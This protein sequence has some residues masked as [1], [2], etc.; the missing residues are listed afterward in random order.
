MRYAQLR[1]MI[2]GDIVRDPLALSSS[3]PA[4]AARAG[5]GGRCPAPPGPGPTVPREWP[6]D[7][8]GYV[9]RGQVGTGTQDEAH[10]GPRHRGPGR[11]A[12]P[13]GRRRH[14][15]QV[16][17]DPEYGLFVLLNHPE[18]YQTMYGHLSRIIVTAGAGSRSRA[19]DRP[20]RKQRAVDRPASAFRDPAAG[21]LAGSADHGQGGKLMGIFTNPARDEQG[22]ELRRRRDRPNTRSRSSRAT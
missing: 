21:R 19:G 4:R 5:P 13:G 3:L 9:T 10:P 12:G 16:G 6:L 15:T 20:E 1:Q 7:E 18:E 2:G 8:A 11:N 17:E 22:N 14:G